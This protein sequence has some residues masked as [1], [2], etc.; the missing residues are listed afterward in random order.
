MVEIAQAIIEKQEGTFDP[1]Q[2]HDRYAEALKQ[3]VIE[4][5]EGAVIDRSEAAPESNVIDLMEALQRSLKGGAEP[6]PKKKKVAA[7]PEPAPKRRAGGGKR[8]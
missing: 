8:G 4:K 1:S 7:K 6:A 3:L 5:S 2:F